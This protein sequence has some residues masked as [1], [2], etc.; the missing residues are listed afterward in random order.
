MKLTQKEI[1]DRLSVLKAQFAFGSAAR[2]LLNEMEDAKDSRALL[3]VVQKARRF[4]FST[5]TLQALIVA[6]KLHQQR[7]FFEA[8]Q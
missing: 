2:D 3:D 5:V 8:K 7:L 1:K 6:G 4:N